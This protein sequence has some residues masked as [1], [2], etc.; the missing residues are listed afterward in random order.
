MASLG[1]VNDHGPDIPVDNGSLRPGHLRRL[2]E[3]LNELDPEILSSVQHPHALLEELNYAVRPRVHER[4][5]P[6]FGAIVS[7]RRRSEGWAENSAVGVAHRRIEDLAD[8]EVRRFADGIV[9]FVVRGSVGVNDLVVFDRSVGSERDLTVVAETSGGTVVQRHPSGV[10]R[11]AGPFGVLRLDGFEWRLEPSLDRWLDVI[12]CAA[13]PIDHRLLK[14]LLRFAVHDVAARNVGATF[15]ISPDGRLTDSAEVRY[16]NPPDFRIERPSDLAPLY[17]VLGQIDGATVFD[18]N[19]MLRHLGVRLVPSLDA[20]H[21]VDGFGGTRHTS[22]LRYS[23]DDPDAV[24]VV[25]SE[26]GPV[27]VMRGG[28]RL[29]H[30]LEPKSQP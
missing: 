11:A 22:A 4:R 26:D 18:H 12:R 15:V 3:E 7:P 16:G 23:F 10:I 5:A 8:D 27:T 28:R 2:G 30:S 17:H 20:E 29:G 1:E 21:D 9:S 13:E 6:S 19:G 14:K 25:I 24:V